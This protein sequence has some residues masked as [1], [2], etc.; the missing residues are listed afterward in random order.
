MFIFLGLNET[1][2]K[3]L[4]RILQFC[5]AIHIMVCKALEDPI[6]VLHVLIL[7]PFGFHMEIQRFS[8]CALR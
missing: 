5:V 8:S 1:Y 7:S 6:G 2:I 3:I 4:M